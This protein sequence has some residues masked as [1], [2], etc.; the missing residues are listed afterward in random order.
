TDDRATQMSLPSVFAEIHPDWYRQADVVGHDDAIEGDL[1]RHACDSTLGRRMLARWLMRDVGGELFVPRPD[2]AIAAAVVRW[3]RPQL[4]A[5][6][7]DLG[8]LAF[9][10]A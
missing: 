7:R 5:L 3:P 8:A 2:G 1:L 10:P 6:S 9:A 4:S